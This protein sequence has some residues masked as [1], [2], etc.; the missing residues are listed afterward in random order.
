MAAFMLSQNESAIDNGA[1]YVLRRNMA[2]YTYGRIA[3]SA[4][5]FARSALLERGRSRSKRSALPGSGR[6]PCWSAAEAEISVR[7]RLGVADGLAGAR[8]KSKLAFGSVE[9]TPGTA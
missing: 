3:P 6:R 9:S 1:R 8:P 4:P 5:R 7:P 2:C